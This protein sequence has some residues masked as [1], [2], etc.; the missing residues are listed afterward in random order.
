MQ[1]QYNFERF[2]MK[3][4]LY[5]RNVVEG[6]KIIKR[7]RRKVLLLLV[8]EILALVLS[9]F[10]AIMVGSFATSKMHSLTGMYF[11]TSAISA[12]LS[13]FL[14]IQVVSIYCDYLYLK[15]LYSNHYYKYGS[16]MKMQLK[17]GN[18]KKDLHLQEAVEAYK[19]YVGD[20]ET[21]C[22]K[23]QEDLQYLLKKKTDNQIL[24]SVLCG[25]LFCSGNKKYRDVIYDVKINKPS[26]G[27]MV[28][29]AWILYYDGDLDEKI[30]FEK[31]KN[32]FLDFWNKKC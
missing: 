14:L 15:Y 9:F 31:L 19:K 16:W 28:L 1:I 18:P 5:K 22:T 32:D 11:L 4:R 10:V 26:A 7:D 6:I 25:L 2:Y 13:S 30:T 17:K 21:N 23:I 20:I 3:K 29:I 24:V 8:K 12:R 27:N